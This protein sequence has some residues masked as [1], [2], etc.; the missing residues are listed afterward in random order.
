MTKE[1]V[2]KCYDCSLEAVPNGTRCEKHSLLSAIRAKE[3]REKNIDKVRE[4]RK[5]YYEKNKDIVKQKSK[6]WAS[7]NKTRKA[8]VSKEWAN[9]NPDKVLNSRMK[10]FGITADVYKE[11]LNKQNNVCCIC[12]R[13]E[14]KGRGRF[15]VDHDHNKEKAGLMYVR[16]LLCNPCNLALGYFEDNIQYMSNAI[17]YIKNH[18]KVSDD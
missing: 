2:M 18:N 15:V 3:W 8:L 12:K 9:N 10:K 13:D 14:P 6:E 16:G 4:A 17:E 1:I 5:K 11:M 7:N